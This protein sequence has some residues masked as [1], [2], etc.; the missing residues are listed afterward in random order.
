MPTAIRAPFPNHNTTTP[1]SNVPCLAAPAAVPGLVVSL[2][3][4][5][6]QGTLGESI[7]R[8]RG[9]WDRVLGCLAAR[10]AVTGEAGAAEDDV[11]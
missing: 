6:W 7:G 4:A 8:G 9:V 1:P 10:S 3:G 11:C 2:K 5:V